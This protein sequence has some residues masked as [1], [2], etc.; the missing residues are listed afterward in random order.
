MGKTQG[1]AKDVEKKRKKE[2]GGDNPETW[3]D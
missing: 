2:R 1:Y 3:R